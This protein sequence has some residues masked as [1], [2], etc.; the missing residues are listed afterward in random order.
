MVRCL[1]AASLILA[2]SVPAF[3]EL[4]I[5]GIKAR[6][7]RQ[8]PERKSLDITPGD[9]L[10]ITFNVTGLRAAAKTDLETFFRVT[11]ADGKVVA[12]NKSTQKDTLA[13]GGGQVPWSIAIGIGLD[14]P[15]G[16]YTVAV[17]FTDK[18]HN[19]SATFERTMTVGTPTFA[20]VRPRLSYD[21]AARTDAGTN[22]LLGNYVFYRLLAVGFDRSM[23]KYD[24]TMVVNCLD[25][26]GTEL[27]PAPLVVNVKS[28][29]E[30]MVKAASDITFNGRILCNRTGTFRLRIVVTDNVTKK[31]ATF[32][33]PLTV[34]E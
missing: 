22:H 33:S 6:H 23:K 16:K 28:D 11:N 1:L 3:A 10:I 27:M 12:E 24:V 30:Q 26:K 8:G 29:N 15:P 20:I 31:S 9:E 18:I 7:G 4:K 14:T 32:E 21:E 5:V 25:D 19:E 2:L 34:T 17:T 13:F